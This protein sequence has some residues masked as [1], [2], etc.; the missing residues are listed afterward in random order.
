MVNFEELVTAGID[1][2][3]LLKRIMGN[4][5]LVKMFVNK[6]VQDQ[7]WEALVEAFN[8]N[9]AEKAERASHTLKGMCGN[10]S[11]HPLFELFTEQ[12]DL[13]RGGSYQEAQAM[14]AQLTP[15]YQEALEHMKQWLA[16]QS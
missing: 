7:T 8:E 12:V 9:D 14:M 16:K 5:A 6:F 3:E 1:M 2:D 4:A 15:K 11:L 10:M 13:L